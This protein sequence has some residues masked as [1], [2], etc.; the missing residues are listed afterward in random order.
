MKAQI[1]NRPLGLRQI[2]VTMAIASTLSSAAQAIEI[3][4][5][6]VY[7]VRVTI[8]NGST[9]S[10][11]LSPDE[12][13]SCSPS[14]SDCNPGGNSNSFWPM[15]ITGAGVSAG[16]KYFNRVNVQAAGTVVITS[17]GRPWGLLPDIHVRSL[18]NTGA[19]LDQTYPGAGL[20]DPPTRDVQFLASADCQ[21]FHHHCCDA[22]GTTAPSGT[23][24]A[25]YDL[26]CPEPQAWNNTADLANARMR[27][28]MEANSNIRGILYA[29]DLTQNAR[30]LREYQWYLDSFLGTGTDVD[31]SHFVYDGQGNHDFGGLG[32]SQILTELRNRDR[33][34]IRTQY[35]EVGTP[36]YSWD[37]HD[38]H[39]VQLNLMP[40][41][42]AEPGRPELDPRG[43]LSFLQN[44]LA[45]YVQ[46]GR[47]VVLIHHYG[48]DS[49]STAQS[50]PPPTWW[51][52][53]QQR[54][55]YWNVIANYN[56]VGIFTGHVHKGPEADLYTRWDRPGDTTLGP[57][58]LNTWTCGAA[59][60]G[61][62]IEVKMNSTN[63]LQVNVL[64][65]NGTGYNTYCVL[66]GD[67]I[68]VDRNFP[69]QGDGAP[70]YPVNTVTKAVAVAGQLH[71]DCT[72][73]PRVKLKA[74]NYM[75]NVTIGL[76][77]TLEATDG[78]V[79]IGVP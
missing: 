12:S 38:V 69:T 11:V 20:T 24:A 48:L 53:P 1:N 16:A 77:M 9:W 39:F 30:F 13:V 66:K 54:T 32:E 10:T 33:S 36:H 35:A 3:N 21:Y 2:I 58:Y 56:V 43:A 52:N 26:Q 49:F 64:D 28:H 72:E 25:P 18:D 15:D 67:A 42:D 75:E 41:D 27:V 14:D 59:R 23:C 71:V 55:D 78:V 8:Q 5:N 6:G 79:R 57:D 62:F 70:L 19:L 34:T 37:W 40:A 22:Q 65:E 68:H 51:W 44:D 47:P 45:M 60:F 73:N 74:G 50:Q 61:T 7:T 46:T 29:G 31:L 17:P 63:Q 4:N 76:P